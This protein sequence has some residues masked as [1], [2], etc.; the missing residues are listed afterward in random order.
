MT[1]ETPEERLG[2]NTKFLAEIQALYESDRGKIASLKRNAGNV[3]ADSRGLTWFYFYLMRH[4]ATRGD[5]DNN[6]CMLV[7]SLMTFDQETMFKGLRPVM[8]ADFGAT[9]AGLRTAERLGRDRHP[10]RG[11]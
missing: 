11:G 6:L 9:L 4:F 7:A 2:R 10:W 5:R 3:L 8:P 1:Q